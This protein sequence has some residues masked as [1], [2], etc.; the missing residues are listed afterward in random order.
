MNSISS[1]LDLVAASP[2]PKV[3]DYAQFGHGWTVVTNHM[4]LV[5]ITAIVML[6]AFPLIAA[7][8]RTK[9][10]PTGFTNFFEA[11]LCYLRDTV[12]RPVLGDQ[13]DRFMPYLWTVFFFIL[14]NNLLGLLPM[15]EM[16]YWMKALGFYPIYGTATGNIYVTGALALVAFIVIQGYAIQQNGIGGY[17][18]HLTGG[19]PAALWPIM[20]PVEIIGMFVKP[21]A[22]MI[23]LFA[24]MFAGGIVLKVLIGFVAMSFGA[25]LIAFIGVGLAVVV[26]SAAMMVLKLFVAF[27]QAYLFMFLTTIFLGQWTHHH[28]HHEEDHHAEHITHGPEPERVA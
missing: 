9:F 7:G 25:G 10:V 19:T 27:L 18:A 16:T 11:I 2:L 1:A 17:L 12:V 6:L 23:R 14:I 3:Q 24:N 20:I 5:M 4:I 15:Y 28:E 21:F 8:Y 13:T 22:L 26:G